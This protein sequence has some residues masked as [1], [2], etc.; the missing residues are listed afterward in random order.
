MEAFVLTESKARKK[1]D[2]VEPGVN[3]LSP[4]HAAESLNLFKRVLNSTHTQYPVWNAGD[5]MEIKT[6]EIVELRDELRRLFQAWL[7]ANANLLRLFKAHPEVAVAC[8][9]GRTFLIPDRDGHPQLAW[10]PEVPSDLNG[11]HKKAAL[12]WFARFLVNPLASKLGGPCARCGKYYEK[13][14]VRQ[15]TYCSTKCGA[16]NT[17]SIATA[18]RRARERV[19]LLHRVQSVIDRYG[20]K[21]RRTEWRV[22]TCKEAGLKPAWLTRAINKGE[23]RLPASEV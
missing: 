2:W 4:K 6:V 12:V 23:L 18:R 13:K 7:D 22:W 11:D 10:S 21:K 9:K 16:G 20:E 17:A 19:A 15:K 1:K 8:S 3:I 5:Q 14:T